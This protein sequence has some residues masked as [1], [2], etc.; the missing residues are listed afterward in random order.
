MFLNVLT[1]IAHWEEVFDAF[2]DAAA[3]AHTHLLPTS[4]T[5]VARWAISAE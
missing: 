5:L 4:A 1:V 2:G 3:A